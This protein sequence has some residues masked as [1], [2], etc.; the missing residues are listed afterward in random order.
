MKER[1]SS[2]YLLQILLLLLVSSSAFTQ[3]PESRALGAYI[4]FFMP[5]LLPAFFRQFE[6]KY[7]ECNSQNCS[8]PTRR[9][10]CYGVMEIH[11]KNKPL[12]S[13]CFSLS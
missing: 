10:N 2:R 8:Q 1:G 7:S 4:Q 9:S 12:S 13:C 3:I 6:K 5:M 11:L